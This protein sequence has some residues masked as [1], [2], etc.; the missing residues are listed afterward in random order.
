VARQ[1]TFSF[2][3]GLATGIAIIAMWTLPFDWK[4]VGRWGMFWIV[5]VTMGIGYLIFFCVIAM[6]VLLYLGRRFP[7]LRPAQRSLLGAVV[8]A[9]SLYA[10]NFIESGT[11]HPVDGLLVL[12][13][14]TATLVGGVVFYV[15][16]P[17]EN[18][19]LVA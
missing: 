16:K 17:S 6:P 15:Y 9:V 11:L 3:I 4:P 2:L 1:L 7:G 8:F 14:V 13:L 19:Q 12:G 10:I 18:V 5:C